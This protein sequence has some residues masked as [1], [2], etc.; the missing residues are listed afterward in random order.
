MDIDI[1]HIRKKLIEKLEINGWNKALDFFMNSSDFD[2]VINALHAEVSE[3][4]R[5]TPPLKDIFNA[6]EFTPYDKTTVFIIGQDPY[7]QLGTADGIAFSCSK[8]MKPE[9][10]LQYIFK[11]IYG[12]YKD[13]DPDLRRWCKQG[14]LPINTA[15]TTQIG[16]VGSHYSI[17]KPFIIQLLDHINHSFH[18]MF[19]LM[20]KKAEEWEPLLDKQVVFKVPH[21]AS[22]AYKSGTWDCKNVFHDVNE[23]LKMNGFPEIIW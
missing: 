19:I 13:R 1:N 12:D 20:G 4:H 14:V 11:A 3:G 5:F 21:P 6:F 10:S 15:L 16:D 17:W 18:G 23:E 22:A 7:P 9:K 2:I 8:K